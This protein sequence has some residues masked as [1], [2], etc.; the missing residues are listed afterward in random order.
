MRLTEQNVKELIIE[1]SM[2]KAVFVYFYMD[3][4]E[5][6][7]TTVAL[8]KAIS[9]DNEF[10]AL[11]E[12]NVQDKVSQAIAMQLGLQSVPA[13][14][15]MQQGR[16]AAA[17][18]GDEIV[19]KLDETIK[20]YMPSLAELL[21]KEALELEEKGEIAQAKAKAK[22]A[23]AEDEKNNAAKLVLARLCIKDKTFDEAHTLLDNPGRELS[24]DQDYRDLVSALTLAEQAAESPEIKEL[25]RKFKEDENNAQIAVEYAVALSDA[26]KKAQALEILFNILKKDLSEEKIKKT[27]LDMLNTMSGDPLQK[28]YRRKLYTIM[29]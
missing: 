18:Q 3:A 27:F 20:E 11:A 4:P 9:D 13:L 6:E 1:T 5:C 17:L 25:E 10:I 12:A 8:K 24:E 21:L 7:A 26:G 19:S 16:P 29:Y 22:A 2:K 14:I 15:V 23:F 28:E